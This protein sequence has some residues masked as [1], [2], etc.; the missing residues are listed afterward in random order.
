M[1]PIIYRATVLLLSALFLISCTSGVKK[2]PEEQ[3]AVITPT[4]TGV[5]APADSPERLL[6]EGKPLDAAMLYL[7]NASRVE[8]SQRQA[9]QLKA[10]QILIDNDYTDMAANV[11]ADIDLYASTEL[12]KTQILYFNI[13]IAI[14]ERRPQQ[15]LQ[16]LELI[17]TRDYS[18]FATEADII[19]MHI[20]TYDLLNDSKQAAF[21]RIQLEPFLVEDRDI[22]SNQ[23]AIVRV[24][25]SMDQEEL[26]A[27]ANQPGVPVAAKA[28]VDLALLIKK[29]NNPFRLT[30]MLTNWKSLHPQ[31]PLRDE[32]IAILAPKAD[33]QPVAAPGSA[34]AALVYDPH[35]PAQHGIDRVHPRAQG[36]GVRDIQG[37]GIGDLRV[38]VLP[39]KGKGVIASAQAAGSPVDRPGAGPQRIVYH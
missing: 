35:A 29:S 14:K 15:S 33:D 13:Q 39:V 7:K 32:V 27:L 37:V 8:Q 20:K 16:M 3:D 10:A 24:F 36:N 21:Y 31:H 6:V 26:S 17:K 1:K 23:I 11:L 4:E 25:Q 34:E 2:A 28:W 19:N 22:V 18:A 9:Y 38:I 5:E 12:E 30:N